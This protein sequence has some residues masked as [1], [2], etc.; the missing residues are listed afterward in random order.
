MKHVNNISEFN[1]IRIHNRHNY[2]D[3]EKEFV[4]FFSN[5]T[6]N[7]KE[8]KYTTAKNN[9]K[10]YNFKIW[11]YVYDNLKE[12]FNKYF[13]VSVESFDTGVNP[14]ISQS[15]VKCPQKTKYVYD[16][17]YIEFE[18]AYPYKINSMIDDGLNSNDGLFSYIFRVVY[19]LKY[20][21]KML[22]FFLNYTF[23]YFYHNKHKYFVNRA[24]NE[25]P[26]FF[27]TFFDSIHEELYYYEYTFLK[28][29]CKRLKRDL[30]MKDSKKKIII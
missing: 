22:R 12:I 7:D 15:F 4:N 1:V 18:R 20:D 23:G 26:D 2:S 17:A 5:L 28:R 8:S 25:I 11:E 3:M 13:S 6:F 9:F 27:Y 24:F 10:I 14:L 19:N 30:I 21:M 29:T 16:I